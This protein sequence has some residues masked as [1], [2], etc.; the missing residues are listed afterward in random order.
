MAPSFHIVASLSCLL[1]ERSSG[2]LFIISLMKHTHYS[3]RG[4]ELLCPPACEFPKEELF[5]LLFVSEE[6]KVNKELPY[7]YIYTSS[8][9]LLALAK[10]CAREFS[11]A[12]SVARQREIGGDR[13]SKLFQEDGGGSC[14]VGPVTRFHQKAAAALGKSHSGRI[15]TSAGRS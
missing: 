1:C 2:R 4:A 13:Q 15:I 3:Q 7:I 12:D 10:Y 5:R 6:Q 14:A 8:C 11:S 9:W